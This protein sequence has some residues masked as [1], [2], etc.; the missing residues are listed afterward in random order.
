MASR[1]LSPSRLD[2]TVVVRRKQPAL[3]R[4]ALLSLLGVGGEVAACGPVEVDGGKN[5]VQVPLNLARDGS[6]AMDAGNPDGAMPQDVVETGV[7][8]SGTD[9]V[10]PT[11]A[12][13]APVTPPDTG[14][15]AGM[16]TDADA[17]NPTVDVPVDNPVDAGMPCR[18]TAITVSG[19][20]INNSYDTQ[21]AVPMVITTTGNCS[22]VGMSI[23][24]TLNYGPEVRFHRP[25]LAI[26]SA[27]NQIRTNLDLTDPMLIGF[28]DYHRNVRV[29]TTI[30]GTTTSGTF[31]R[32]RY[33]A[34]I[35]SGGTVFG[36]F[37]GTT[38]YNAR[39]QLN[40]TT[41][42]SRPDDFNREA[43]I[44]VD[45]TNDSGTSL[46][47]H[48]S[49]S[50]CDFGST[51]NT[52]TDEVMDGSGRTQRCFIP[53]MITGDRSGACDV[54]EGRVFTYPGGGASF[55]MQIRGVD[56]TRIRNATPVGGYIRAAVYITDVARNVT[57]ANY[58]FRRSD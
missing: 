32:K 49:L 6:V 44:G 20:D 9:A 47:W 57:V 56:F 36:T 4:I 46:L 17:G 33:P 52:C 26:D 40:D 51:V 29:S 42:P 2:R 24:F 35:V 55:G 27:R 21:T 30:N 38:E 23:P 58:R 25:V 39:V 22:D 19:D 7:A 53:N 8:E 37:G 3:T 1:L 50:S 12:G 11:E 45:F 41:T 10:M 16:G 28:P 54:L 14:N 34:T 48:G 5:F 18:P 43:L 13:D 31:L 15:D